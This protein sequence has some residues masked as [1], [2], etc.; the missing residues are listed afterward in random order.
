VPVKARRRKSQKRVIGNLEVELQRAVD[1]G[2][3]R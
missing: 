1:Y 2:L 3:E